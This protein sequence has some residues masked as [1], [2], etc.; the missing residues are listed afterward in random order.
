MW[1]RPEQVPLLMDVW[2]APHLRGRGIGRRMIEK[3]EQSARERGFPCVYIQVQAEKNPRAVELY[4]RLGYRPLQS[5][6]YRDL[7]HNVDEQGNV[8]EGVELIVDMQKWL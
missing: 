1:E 5:K 8:H 2:V 4:Q 7:Y 6:P 3:L